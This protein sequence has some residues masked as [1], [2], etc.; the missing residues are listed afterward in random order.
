[1]VDGFDRTTG[2]YN[3]SRHSFDVYYG[4]PIAADGRYFN[5]ADNDAVRGGIV[6]LSDYTGVFWFLGDESVANRSL[7]TV[8]QNILRN[9]LE[10]GGKLFVTGSEIGYD[11][12]RAASPNNSLAFYTGYLKANYVGDQASGLV[13]SGANGSIF[14]GLN[15]QFGQT[16]I[17]DYPDYISPAGGSIAALMYNGTQIAAIQYAGPFGA[18]P[19]NGASQSSGKLVYI[20]FAFETIASDATR[21]TLIA[22]ILDYFEGTTGVSE[23]AGTGALPREFALYQNYPNPFNPLTTIVFDIPAGVAMPTDVTVYDMLGRE[24][25]TLVNEFKSP[26]RHSVS[27]DATGLASGVYVYRLE[28]GEHRVTRKLLLLR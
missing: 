19:V 9:Y 1:V 23:T 4:S 13:F 28:S 12:G 21:N 2:S 11:L 20:G 22:R 14:Q 5:S 3:L 17:E 7:D 15:G 18:S 24:V 16:Y 10:Q 27:F 6:N 25:R 26:G 8:E